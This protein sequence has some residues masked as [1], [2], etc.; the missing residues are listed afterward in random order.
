MLLPGHNGVLVM[1]APDYTTASRFLMEMRID[2]WND[3][4][5]YESVTP[6]EAMAITAERFAADD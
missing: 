5:L 2:N 4:D 1:E 6:Q 3:V